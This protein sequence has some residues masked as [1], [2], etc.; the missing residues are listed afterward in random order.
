MMYCTGG[1]SCPRKRF[2][3]HSSL[4]VEQCCISLSGGQGCYFLA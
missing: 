2:R 4:A 3:C 1:I